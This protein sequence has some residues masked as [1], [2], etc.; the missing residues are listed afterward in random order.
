MDSTDSLWLA[1]YQRNLL[2]F[3]PRIIIF[4]IGTLKVEGAFNHAEI[5]NTNA[6]YIIDGGDLLHGEKKLL[7]LLW[8]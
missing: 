2:Y 1:G 3:V 4:E 5:D 7:M 6:Y 8:S